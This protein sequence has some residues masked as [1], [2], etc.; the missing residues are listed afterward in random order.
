MAV[1]FSIISFG[2]ALA[3]TFAPRFKNMRH[4]LMQN[5]LF[6]MYLADLPN[7]LQLVLSTSYNNPKLTA[8]NQFS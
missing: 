7:C 2:G 3:H 6:V 4:S 8:L 1:N 5:R